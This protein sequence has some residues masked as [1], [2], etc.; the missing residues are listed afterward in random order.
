MTGEED[1]VPAEWVVSGGGELFSIASNDRWNLKK[2][3][4]NVITRRTEES[5]PDT[6]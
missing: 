4:S 1:P 3:E 5:C 6:P 2:R